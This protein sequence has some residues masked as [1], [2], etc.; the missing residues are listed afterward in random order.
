MPAGLCRRLRGHSVTCTHVAGMNGEKNERCERQIGV[1]SK[2]LCQR[3]SRTETP[4]LLQDA[5]AL[6]SAS[7][8]AST[9]RLLQGKSASC[10]HDCLSPHRS[11]LLD[12]YVCR[13][14][15]FSMHLVM[16]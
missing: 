2:L 12:R 4:A 9:A 1:A 13:T 6:P 14:D 15:T 8:T 10:M 7:P 11:G 3:A 5:A 16:L